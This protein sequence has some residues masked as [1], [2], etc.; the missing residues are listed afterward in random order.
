MSSRDDASAYRAIIT[1]VSEAL[2]TLDQYI[3]P[4]FVDH[5][6]IALQPTGLEGFKHWARSARGAF[7]NIPVTVEDLLVDGD[8]LA[9]R[10]TWRGS[11]LGNLMGV[12]ATGRTVEFPAFHIVRFSMA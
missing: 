1:A 6:A 10:V 8:K 3:A 12:P 9:A 2:Q 11:H 7:P 4:D 5:N